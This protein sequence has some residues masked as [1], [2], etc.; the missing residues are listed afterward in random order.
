MHRDLLHYRILYC[1]DPHRAMDV[2]QTVPLLYFTAHESEVYQKLGF[3]NWVKLACTA[4]LLLEDGVLVRALG[5]MEINN[6]NHTFSRKSLRYW[7]C[8]SFLAR[9]NFFRLLFFLNTACARSDKL[10]F[11]CYNLEIRMNT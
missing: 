9:P 3:C 5:K 10:C 6:T 4:E 2:L 11:S 8:W 1:N 7:R